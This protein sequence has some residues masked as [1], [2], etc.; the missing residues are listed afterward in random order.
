MPA[1]PLTCLRRRRR[2]IAAIAICLLIWQA[3][4]ASLLAAE[5][6]ALA[7]SGYDAGVICH[8][9]GD[10]G[11]AAPADRGNHGQDCC[12]WCMAASTPVLP[13][14]APGVVRPSVIR[15]GGRCRP[16]AAPGHFAS[17]RARRIFASASDRSLNL[18]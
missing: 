16:C 5:A 15:A 11:G 1:A 9:D 8:S 6:A 7:A 13:G 2:P 4:A 17:R 12:T 14:Q 3:L 10:P 18:A